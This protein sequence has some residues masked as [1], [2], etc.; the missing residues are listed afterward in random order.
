L[1]KDSEDEPA[2]EPKLRASSRARTATAATKTKTATTTAKAKAAPQAKPKANG[3]AGKGKAVAEA[4]GKDTAPKKAT[5]PK[6]DVKV[7]PAINKLATVP[8]H[9][10]PCPQLFGCGAGNFGQLGM[11]PD[12]L[13][14]YNKMKRNLLVQAKIDA[15]EYGGTGA[16]LESVAAGG[17]HTLFT[18]ETGKVCWR[19][20][21]CSCLC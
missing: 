8:E 2:D 15:G 13:E 16:G 1:K 19:I 4:N 3:T 14:E 12:Y 10:R 20:Y 18:D 5:A 11:G 7:E 17:M 9:I 6:K 21:H